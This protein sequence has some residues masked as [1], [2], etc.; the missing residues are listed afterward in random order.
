M[1]YAKKKKGVQRRRKSMG[2]RA[3]IRRHTDRPRLSVFRSLKNISCQVIDD[4]NGRTLAAASSLDKDL[5]SSVS[6]LKKTEVAAKV[7]AALAERAKAAGVS[8]VA[9]DRGHYKFHGRVKALA[10]S[11]R[12]GGLEF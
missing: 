12:E 4:E 6:G 10:D 1:V 3:K 8:Q 11:A 9:F 2:V 5:K 7:G